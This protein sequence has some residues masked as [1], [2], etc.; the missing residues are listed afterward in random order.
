MHFMHLHNLHPLLDVT[1]ILVIRHVA[2]LVLPFKNWV[3]LDGI[4]KIV[5]FKFKNSQNG[6]RSIRTHILNIFWL[7]YANAVR[8][9]PAKTDMHL[10]KWHERTAAISAE[11]YATSIMHTQAGPRSNNAKNNKVKIILACTVDMLFYIIDCV[12]RLERF[13][14]PNSD[15]GIKKILSTT[16]SQTFQGLYF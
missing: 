7:L 5:F 6:S 14:I 2:H 10:T 11:R 8:T 1:E 9:V 3:I 12:C 4:I 15:V 13:K 16:Q